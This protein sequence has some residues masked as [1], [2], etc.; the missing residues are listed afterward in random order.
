LPALAGKAPAL[1]RLMH[2]MHE[3]LGMVMILLLALHIGAAL[4]H[5]FIDKGA[6]LRRMLPF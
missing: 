6:T 2:E 4:K 3:T 5:H 1:G